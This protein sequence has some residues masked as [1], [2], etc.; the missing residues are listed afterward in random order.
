M[1]SSSKKIPIKKV[2]GTQDILC[3]ALQN[4]LIETTKKHLTLYTFHEISTP[5]LEPVELFSRSLGTATDVVNKEMF[6]I[7]P[8]RETTE[9]ICLRPEAT[10]S[11]AR[12]FV[13]NGIQSVPWKVFSFGSMFR[14]ERPQ[15]G[16]FR[17]FRQVTIENIGAQSIAYDAQL[18]SMLDKLFGTTLLLKNYALQINFLGCRADRTNYTKKI[19]QE[20]KDSYASS[21]CKTCQMR[22]EKNVLRIFDCKNEDCQKQYATLPVLTNH[23][24]SPCNNE[25]QQVQ[26]QLQL[27]SVSYIVQPHLVRGLDYYNKTVFEFVSAELGAQNAFCAGGRY[28]SLIQEVGGKQDAPSVGAAIGIERLLLLLEPL[29]AHYQLENQA[30]VHALIPLDNAQASLTLMVADHLRTH[31]IAVTALLDGSLKSRMRKADKQ[32]L[33]TAILLGSDEQDAGTATV[34]C[35]QTGNTKTVTQ[36]HLVDYLKKLI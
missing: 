32:Q 15:K 6:T 14:Y 10:A 23:L 19:A 1:N 12:A 30:P 2:K 28:D 22:L 34:K 11:T 18:I 7:K 24:C 17:E 8:H 31:H 35:L 29:K 27:L 21:I 16:R 9:F 20:V 13:E 26:N 33:R 5:I 36:T 3:L 4:F 25:W